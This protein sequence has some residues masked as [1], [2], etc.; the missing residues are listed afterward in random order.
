LGRTA[1]KFG[2]KRINRVEL[3]DPLQ[4][5]LNVT[6]S[7]QTNLKIMSVGDSVGIQF[8]NILEEA[9]TRDEKGKT[10]ENNN[11]HRVVYQTAWGNHESVS[12]TG[13]VNGGGALAAFRMTGWLVEE[14]K[15][16][17]PPNASPKTHGGAGGWLPEHVEQLLQHNYSINHTTNTTTTANSNDKINTNATTANEFDAMIYRIP[18]GW[19]KL[20]VITKDRLKESLILARKLFGIRTAIVQTLFLNVSSLLCMHVLVFKKYDCNL[21]QH[22]S[23]NHRCHKNITDSDDN[24]HC[25]HRC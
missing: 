20:R 16:R 3:S 5:I 17:P 22:F 14:G 6:T 2:K 7:I 12:A 10:V 4:N 23:F 11:F 19:M 18:H 13:P 9:M 8:H 1:N 15:G 24:R 25:N 21:M